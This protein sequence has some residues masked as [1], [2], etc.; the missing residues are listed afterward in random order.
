MTNFVD[1]Y[2]DLPSRVSEVWERLRNPGQQK[3]ERDLSVTAMLM[4]A[5]TGLAMPQ[6][7]LK[8]GS[9][10]SG[11]HPSF[12]GVNQAHYKSVHTHCE[13]FLKQ[14]ISAIEC[15]K[16]IS[17]MHCPNMSDIRDAIECGNKGETVFELTEHTLDCFVYVV[18]NALA[19]NNIVALGN[20]VNEITNLG[21]FSQSKSKSKLNCKCKNKGDYLV[22]AITTNKF[23]DFLNTWFRMLTLKDQSSDN[24][25]TST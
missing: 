15:L 19:H 1:I 3:S 22:V 5:A 12:N 4:A 7:H 25:G 8:K 21:F 16:N 2:Q 9:N 17:F 6:E 13:E 20:S 14:K 18:R 11:E 24:Q 10:N 23:Q